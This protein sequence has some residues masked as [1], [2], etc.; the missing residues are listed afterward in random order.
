M[1]GRVTLTLPNVQD[2]LELL[3]DVRIDD[4]HRALYR[5]RYNAAPTDQHWVVTPE[6]KLVP[7]KWGY[8][9]RHGLL[10]NSRSETASV[11]GKRPVIVPADGFYEWKDKHP[12]WFRPREGK[13]L[14]MAGLEREGAFVI[15]T[16]AANAFMQDV[17]DRMPALLPREAIGDWLQRA[18]SGLLVPARNDFLTATEVSPRVNDVRNDDA[19]L[20]IATPRRQLSMF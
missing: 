17:H 14:Y 12:V 15:L 8:M 9:G 10:I 1:C 6:R 18:D 20:V 19:A 5:P 16:T 3:E 2:V 13:L 4:E 7:S 11:Q